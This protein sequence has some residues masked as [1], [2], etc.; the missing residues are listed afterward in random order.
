MPV[1]IKISAAGK[2]KILVKVQTCSQQVEGGEIMKS[3]NFVSMQ[4]VYAREMIEK[5]HYEGEY[6]I[7]D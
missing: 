5:W 2:I 1:K 4:E 7:Y 3:F 6:A